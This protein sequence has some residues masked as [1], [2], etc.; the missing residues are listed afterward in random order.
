MRQVLSFPNK[1]NKQTKVQSKAVVVHQP[2][3]RKVEAKHN[4]SAMVVLLLPMCTYLLPWLILKVLDSFSGRF[5]YG[6]DW[7]HQT[8]RRGRCGRHTHLSAFSCRISTRSHRIS[9]SRA[10]RG[11]MDAKSTHSSSSP[12]STLA[13]STTLRSTSAVAVVNL[14]DSEDL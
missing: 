9:G 13:T 8:H 14:L 1:Q 6:G 10:G 12:S 5:C 3:K 2:K 7:W 4:F 11:S